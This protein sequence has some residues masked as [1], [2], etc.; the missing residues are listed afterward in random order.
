LWVSGGPGDL[1]FGKPARAGVGFFYRG[2]SVLQGLAILASGNQPAPG[3][4]GFSRGFWS[5]WMIVIWS[6]K[7]AELVVAPNQIDDELQ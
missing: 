1:R 3:L 7:T 4:A 6:S 5:R 2:K